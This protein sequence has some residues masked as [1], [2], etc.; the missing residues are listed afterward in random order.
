MDTNCPDNAM[1]MW[2]DI[3]HL[4][5]THTF[6]VVPKAEKWVL[7]ILENSTMSYGRNS[8]TSRRN[9]SLE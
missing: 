3:H 2:K 1:P 8:T 7:H 9:H 4:W 5:D 6:A